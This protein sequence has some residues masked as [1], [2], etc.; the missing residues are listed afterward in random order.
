MR[1]NGVFIEFFLC[2]QICGSVRAI[3][4]YCHC[5]VNS[6]WSSLR[7]LFFYYWLSSSFPFD[8]TLCVCLCACCVC[9]CVWGVCVCVHTCVCVR[10]CDC[11]CVWFCGC[12]CLTDCAS[13]GVQEWICTVNMHI[14]AYK[15]FVCTLWF[16]IHS[17]ETAPISQSTCLQRWWKRE[18]EDGG[19]L[20]KTSSFRDPLC[21][22]RCSSKDVLGTPESHFCQEVNAFISRVPR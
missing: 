16:V 17:L 2:G 9:V 20:S 10:L 4:D 7:M 14:H 8:F 15:F 5:S 11:V 1:A 22:H 21:C 19:K 12:L 6:V 13:C 3:Q 18:A